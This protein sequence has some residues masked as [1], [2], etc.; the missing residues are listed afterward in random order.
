MKSL[1][2]GYPALSDAHR[3]PTVAVMTRRQPDD[4][5]VGTARD[6]IPPGPGPAIAAALLLAAQ[7]CSGA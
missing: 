3:L 6:S 4:D 5:P 7:R 2:F 1:I